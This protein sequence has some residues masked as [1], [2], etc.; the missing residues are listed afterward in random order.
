MMTWLEMDFETA[1]KELALARVPPSPYHHHASPALLLHAPWVPLERC[2]PERWL[3]GT[4]LQVGEERAPSQAQVR[5]HA[6]PLARPN[7]TRTDNLCR[8]ALCRVVLHDGVWAPTREAFR[9]ERAA[10]EQLKKLHELDLACLQQRKDEMKRQMEQRSSG[11]RQEEE[12]D[13]D[14]EEEEDQAN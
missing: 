6:E 5:R 1:Y 3:Q 14:E 12:E 8:V 7:T 13:D 9:A 2:E 10:S 11:F 4:A